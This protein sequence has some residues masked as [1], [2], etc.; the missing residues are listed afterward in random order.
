MPGLLRTQIV[1]HA[2]TESRQLKT[3]T[4]IPQGSILGPTLFIYYIN[5]VF[6]RMENVCVKMFADD[7]I[8][9]YSDVNWPNVHHRLQ[10][11]LDIYVYMGTKK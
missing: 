6:N 10:N 7:C 4:G 3:I 11:A 8:L 1:R 9:Y 5:E 2:G